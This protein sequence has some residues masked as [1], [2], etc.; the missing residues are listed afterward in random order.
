MSVK[1]D[2]IVYGW[3]TSIWLSAL[4]VSEVDEQ[5]LCVYVTTVLPVERQN[6][7]QVTL[8][9]QLFKR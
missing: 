1:T 7:C 5:D 4:P 3:P 6:K 8:A 9:S 2:V